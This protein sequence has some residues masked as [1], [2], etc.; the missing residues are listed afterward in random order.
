[1]D[2]EPTAKKH[3]NFCFGKNSYETRAEY[4]TEYRKK[5]REKRNAYVECECGAKF[6]ELCVY[7][8]RFSN[9]HIEWVKQNEGTK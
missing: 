4:M 7:S 3:L 1:M 5:Y 9:R 6:Q 2:W 8:H